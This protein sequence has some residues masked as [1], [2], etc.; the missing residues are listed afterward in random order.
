[1]WKAAVK[2]IGSYSIHSI[3]KALRLNYSDLK[4]HH[5]TA[6]QIQ[7]PD[8]PSGDVA[9][10]RQLIIVSI[11]MAVQSDFSNK[12]VIIFGPLKFVISSFPDLK[13]KVQVA[14]ISGT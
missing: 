6:N 1:M 4:D 10:I 8:G 7:R 13:G 5:G 14:A 11:P 2:L 12:V 3:S 9:F